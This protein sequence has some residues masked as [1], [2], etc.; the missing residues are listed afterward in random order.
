MEVKVA[1]AFFL[2]RSVAGQVI[3]RENG[4]EVVVKADLGGG[5]DRDEEG[6]E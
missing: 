3:L 5:E 1:L 6:D 2:A 4:A